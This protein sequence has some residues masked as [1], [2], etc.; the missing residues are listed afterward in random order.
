MSEPVN[1]PGSRYQIAGTTTRTDSFHCGT[2]GCPLGTHLADVTAHEIRDCV[3]Y[4][5]DRL[6]LIEH[7]EP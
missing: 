6:A 2:C 3:M 4:L 7:R 1:N 5:A